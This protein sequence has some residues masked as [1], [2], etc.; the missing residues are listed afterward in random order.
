MAARSSTK[1]SLADGGATLTAWVDAGQP[2][3]DSFISS[4]ASYV[5]WTRSLRSH[6]AKR[7]EG[8]FETEHADFRAMYRPFSRT[9]VYFDRMLNHERSQLP[10]FFPSPMETLV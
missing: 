8:E 10:L 7:R 4:D 6:L 2:S 3:V 5:K 1:L 9:R